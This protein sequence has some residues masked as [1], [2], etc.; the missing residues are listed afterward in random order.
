MI[1]TSFNG[2]VNLYAV[3]TENSHLNFRSIEV[4]PFL[5]HKQGTAL[6][7]SFDNLCAMRVPEFDKILFK[8]FTCWYYSLF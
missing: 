3:G 6:Y 4:A 2:A 7:S 8:L 5:K 1:M